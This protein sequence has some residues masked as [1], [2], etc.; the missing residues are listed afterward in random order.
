MTHVCKWHSLPQERL[1]LQFRPK[2]HRTTIVSFWHLPCSCRHEPMKLQYNFAE[3]DAIAN[4]EPRCTIYKVLSTAH[5]VRHSLFLWVWQTRCLRCPRIIFET[6][7]ACGWSAAVLPFFASS[8]VVVF[9]A[10]AR[11]TCAAHARTLERP[12][13]Q[14]ASLVYGYPWSVWR[15][16]AQKPNWHMDDGFPGCVNS[17]FKV[18]HWR[19][20]A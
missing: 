17:T 15:L 7:I 16:Q 4:T 19:L 18:R 12:I 10:S 8:Q 20:L 9:D 2:K 1:I 11:K 13:R 14:H 6:W 5:N 3:N